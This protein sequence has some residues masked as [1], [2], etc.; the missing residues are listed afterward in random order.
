MST[1][2]CTLRR[3]LLFFFLL[4][5][6]TA[7]FHL[8]GV[9]Q[10]QPAVQQVPSDF[11]CQESVTFEDVAPG[12]YSTVLQIGNYAFAERF[13]GQPLT[14]S[15][16]TFDILGATATNPLTL[17]VAFPDA[18]GFPHNVL[19][20]EYPAFEGSNSIVGIGPMG[21][22]GVT[23]SSFGEG[24]VAILFAENRSQ[25]R[26]DVFGNNNGSATARFFRRDGSLIASLE[27]ATLTNTTY[28]FRR[29]G[30]V[31]D[32]AGV[33]IH[34]TDDDG[35]AYDN[36]CASSDI[37]PSVAVTDASGS[38][39]V[40]VPI[41]GSVT[42]PDGSPLVSWSYIAG[43]GVEP[44]ATCHFADE[45]S[46]STS[47][48]CT[49]DGTFAL[50]L[51]ADDGVNPVVV[52]TGTLTLTNVAPTAVFGAGSPIDEGTSSALSLT[53]ALDPGLADTS[54]GFHYSFA[55]D[56]QS[57]AL[58]AGYFSAAVSNITNCL[59]PDDGN[60]TVKGRIIDKDGGLTTYQRQVLVRN[61]PPSVGPINAPVAPVQV[62]TTIHTA[63]AFTDAG[64]LDTHS[65][66][67]HWGDGSTSAATISETNG[68]GIAG[69]SH[70]YHQPGFYTVELTLTDDDGG[71]G[72]SRFQFVIVFDPDGGFVTGGGWIDSPAG[73]FIQ[74]RALLGPARFGFVSKYQ[75]GAVS[76]IGQVEFQ[77]QGANVNFHGRSQEWLV[78]ASGAAKFRGS[79]T[80]N[81]KGEFGFMITVRDGRAGDGVDRFWIRIW[82]KFS[83]N[84]IYSN[85]SGD[86][87]EAGATDAVERG[88]IVVHD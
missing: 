27:F 79:G 22:G 33:S 75:K 6:G 55:C 63:A 82:D 61:L 18:A 37:A 62:N 23:S 14:L 54:T 24:S 9:L 76:P 44:A 74:D 73:A 67:W 11:G 77:F 30:N 70:V 43:A 1:T 46:A 7:P 10:A 17:Q 19:V 29:L 42:D 87:E 88:S 69:G 85:Q 49:D 12:I 39:G 80:I 41:S 71:A 65:G 8:N 64:V 72:Q 51:T 25:L 50:T 2:F 68:A 5:A 45:R 53:N 20:V 48:N 21:V 60:H 3:R 57:G 52:A 28:A 59:F 83:G 86:A 47:V 78:V 26:L 16:G 13:T 36:I 40:A 34:T 84:E 38:E 4:T 56:G 58:A 66:I 81:G 15:G 35:L 31:S 32:I